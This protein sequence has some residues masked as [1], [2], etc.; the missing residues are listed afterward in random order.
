[1]Y[2]KGF[3]DVNAL[4]TNRFSLDQISEAIDDAQKGALK[5]VIVIGGES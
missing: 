3:L 4:L 2:R 5:N 1:M